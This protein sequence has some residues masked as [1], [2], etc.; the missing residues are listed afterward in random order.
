MWGQKI[1]DTVRSLYPDPDPHTKQKK[2]SRYP[3]FM[4]GQKYSLTNI[5]DTAGSIH[6]D[7]E[8]RGISLSGFSGRFK[9][10]RCKLLAGT[11]P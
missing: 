2:E 11:E 5:T 6:P 10:S 9:Q 7:N 3:D 4:Y 8:T 1:C